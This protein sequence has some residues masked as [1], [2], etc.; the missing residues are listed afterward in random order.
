MC[1]DKFIIES[2]NGVLVFHLEDRLFSIAII[3]TRILREFGGVFNA[4]R[5]RIFT[6]R[7]YASA[8]YPVIVCLSILLSVRHNSVFYQQDG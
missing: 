7:R 8:V 3:A 4:N 2:D 1:F 5:P 6:A